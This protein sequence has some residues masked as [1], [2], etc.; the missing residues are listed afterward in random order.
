[1]QEKYD[2]LDKRV[3][4]LSKVLQDLSDRDDNIY[5]VIFESEPLPDNLRTGGIN[6]S[7]IYAELKDLPESKVISNTLSKLESLEKTHLCAIQIL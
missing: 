5:R 1:M 2:I 6:K 7:K 4:A 3:D